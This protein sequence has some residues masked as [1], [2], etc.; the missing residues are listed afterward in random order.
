MVVDAPDA[1]N[2]AKA[3]AV[4][5]GRLAAPPVREKGIGRSSGSVFI[6]RKGGP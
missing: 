6:F 5:S 1:R 4:G 2:R 3:V